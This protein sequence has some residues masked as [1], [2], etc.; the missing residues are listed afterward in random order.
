[1]KLAVVSICKNEAKTIQELIRRI[2]K[3][4]KGVSLIDVIVINDGSTDKTAE[5][6]EKS[7]ATVYG[8]HDSKGLAFRLLC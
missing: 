5:L 7:G 4:I 8:S 1:M 6:A 3:K 2:P